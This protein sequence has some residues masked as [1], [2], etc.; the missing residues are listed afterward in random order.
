MN[1]KGYVVTC[2]KCE[3]SNIKYDHLNSFINVNDNKTS[4]PVKCLDC[5][6]ETTETS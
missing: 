3:S 5:G 2:S 4:T 1:K 6:Y